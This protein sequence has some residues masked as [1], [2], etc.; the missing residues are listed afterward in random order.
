MSH[1]SACD[2]YNPL[3]KATTLESP[4]IRSAASSLIAVNSDLSN[5]TELSLRHTIMFRLRSTSY[6]SNIK[7]CIVHVSRKWDSIL[8]RMR[9]QMI[10]LR[11]VKLVKRYVSDNLENSLS[12]TC[13]TCREIGE[14]ICAWQIGNKTISWVIGFLVEIWSS[15]FPNTKKLQLHNWADLFYWHNLYTDV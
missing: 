6:K 1:G 11:S 4:Q 12:N 13:I 10:V 9:Y 2:L 14:E 8:L 5:T 7:P 3:R 15:D